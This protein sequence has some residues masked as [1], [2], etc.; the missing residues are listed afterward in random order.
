M[1]IVS[2]LKSTKTSKDKGIQKTFTHKM[3][4]VQLH[5]KT[6]D[7]TKYINACAN[8]SFTHHVPRVCYVHDSPGRYPYFESVQF[9]SHN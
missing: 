8:S 3:G 4:I 1:E 6:P 2:N 7:Q 5:K 9:N